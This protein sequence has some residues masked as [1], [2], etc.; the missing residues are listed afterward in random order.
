VRAGAP[1]RVGGARS[2]LGPRLSLLAQA[3]AVPLSTEPRGVA[4]VVTGDVPADQVHR[5]SM[6][7]PDVTRGEGVLTTRLHHFHPQE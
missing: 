5:L 2:A 4:V 6:M 3:G 1:L 7:L